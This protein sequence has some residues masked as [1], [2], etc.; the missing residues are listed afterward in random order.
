[1][2]NQARIYVG[3]LSSRAREDDVERFFKGYG[4][5]KEV[6]LKNGYGFVEFEDVR[7]A[8]DAVHDLN[9]KDLCGERV[10]IE[11]AR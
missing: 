9:D 4:R 2:S 5:I 10:R 3:H 8:E 11:H 7:D 1:M 6:N